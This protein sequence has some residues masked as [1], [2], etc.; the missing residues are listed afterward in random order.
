MA[1]AP[2]PSPRDAQQGANAGS[3]ATAAGRPPTLKCTHGPG[4]PWLVSFL[5]I[6]IL[7]GFSL[8]T[9]QAYCRL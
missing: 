1:E 7:S 3:R 9:R 2:I 4:R 5:C 6:N 8:R